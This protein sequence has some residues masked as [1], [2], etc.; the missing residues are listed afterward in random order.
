MDCSTPCP[1][2]SPGVCSSCPFSGWCHP[3]ILSPVTPFSCLQSFP[4]SVFSSESALCTRWPKYWSFSF[5]VSPSSEH[6]VLISFRIYL[7][8][9]LA[10]QGTLKI[11]LQHHSSKAWTLQHLSLLYGPTL[12]SIQDYWKEKNQNIA[13]TIQAF[14]SK[15]MSLPFNTLSSI[16][17]SIIYIYTT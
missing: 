11:L 15:V 12:I 17:N 13:L 6:S 9:L 5:S 7:F 16:L 2:L 3:T 1:S 14:V 4:K 8:D 10:V